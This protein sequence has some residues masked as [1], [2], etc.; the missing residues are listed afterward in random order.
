MVR[1]LV[2]ARN[3]AQLKVQIEAHNCPLEA[4]IIWAQFDFTRIK[5]PSL[6]YNKGSTI[7]CNK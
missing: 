1:A 5:S 7:I 2:D 3:I 6:A 4:S